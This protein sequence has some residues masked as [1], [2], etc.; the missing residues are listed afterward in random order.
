MSPL[1]GSTPLAFELAC[2]NATLTTMGNAVR[3]I[4]GLTP[5][6]REIHFWKIAI[7]SLNIAVKEPRYIKA[8]T[9]NLQTALNLSG[10][11]AQRSDT[12]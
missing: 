5:G 6:Q 2:T 4:A 3:L 11:L 9:I 10:M 12:P 7:H 8:A 1:I